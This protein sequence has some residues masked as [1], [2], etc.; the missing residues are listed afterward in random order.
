[1]GAA[2]TIALKRRHMRTLQNTSFADRQKAA[3]EAKQALLAKFKPKPTVTDP[4]AHKRD[5]IEATEREEKRRKLE[6]DKEAKRQAK[7]E[8]AEA[9]RQAAQAE[10]DAELSVKRNERKER[11][12]AAAADQRTRREAKYDAYKALR[13]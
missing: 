3:A 2:A 8:A 13:G 9:R 7:A 12:A 4:L 10:E 6:A 1:M 11:K 5:E